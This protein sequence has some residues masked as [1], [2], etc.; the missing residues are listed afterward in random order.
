MSQQTPWKGFRRKETKEKI[1][2]GHNKVRDRWLMRET[3]I[4]ELRRK[5]KKRINLSRKEFQL[6]TDIKKK[7]SSRSL[8][9]ARRVTVKHKRDET[10]EG[11]TARRRCQRWGQTAAGLQAGRINGDDGDKTDRSERFWLN[12]RGLR[13]RVNF[14]PGCTLWRSCT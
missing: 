8:T 4:Q 14:E 1:W 3:N 7:K 11:S 9:D 6:C 13:R 10:S 12:E 2:I 5:K